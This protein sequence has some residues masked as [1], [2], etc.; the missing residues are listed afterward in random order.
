MAGK[1][2][3]VTRDRNER[4]HPGHQ[5]LAL[6]IGKF[7]KFFRASD[8]RLFQKNGSAQESEEVFD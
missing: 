5:E 7:R 8:L 3:T 2:F 1:R 6:P 4:L